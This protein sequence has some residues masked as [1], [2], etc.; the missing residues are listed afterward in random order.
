MTR[1]IRK[2]NEEYI[3]DRKVT[4]NYIRDDEFW[5]F[6]LGEIKDSCNC[7]QSVLD[8]VSYIGFASLKADLRK[9]IEGDVFQQVL[10]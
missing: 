1:D 2:I 3:I 9:Y 6:L 10:H 8:W 7:G 4:D 5:K